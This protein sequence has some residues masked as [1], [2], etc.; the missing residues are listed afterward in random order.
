MVLRKKW[1]RGAL[2]IAAIGSSPALLVVGGVWGIAD[3]RAD[4]VECKQDETSASQLAEKNVSAA[5]QAL[6]AARA[7]C[8][9]TESAFIAELERN[10]VRWEQVAQ[11]AAAERSAAEQAAAAAANEQQ[12][13]QT[14]PQ[15][16]TEIAASYKRALNDTYAGRWADADK[17][18][19]GAE[20]ALSS[21][22]GTSVAQSKPYQDLGSQFGALRKKIDA[23][24]QQIEKQQAAKEAAQAAADAKVEKPAPC[25]KLARTFGAGSALTDLQKDEA[26]K[27]YQGQYF[28]WDL[29]V[30]EVVSGPLGGIHVSAEGANWPDLGPIQI[31]YDDATWARQLTKDTV[32]RLKGKLRSMTLGILIADGCTRSNCQ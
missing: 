14:F 10:I 8:P 18:L 32:W 20:T 28:Q 12:A 1:A 3:A 2:Q 19:S 7:K 16:S 13:V 25:A 4:A 17:D 31:E 23:Q 27:Q 21:F 11:K 24:L 22:N 29:K 5:R 9:D 15:K 26:W 6:N 30:T